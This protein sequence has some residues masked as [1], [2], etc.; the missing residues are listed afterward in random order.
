MITV[1][2]A[3]IILSSLFKFPAIS[4]YEPCKLVCADTFIISRQGKK[5][6][7]S[8]SYNFCNLNSSRIKLVKTRIINTGKDGE[9]NGK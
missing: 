3:I 4:I 6:Q 7:T 1:N 5:V 9:G 8:E 2:S